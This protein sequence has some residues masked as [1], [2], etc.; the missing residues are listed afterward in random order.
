M[1]YKVDLHVHSHYSHDGCMRPD[2]IIQYAKAK[3]LDAVAICDH[4]HFF[5]DEIGDYPVI[6]GCEFSTPYGHLLGLFLTAPIEEKDFA[7]IVGAI[8]AQGGI[9]VLAHPFQHK[10]DVESVAHLVDGVE[11]WNSRACRKN[12]AAN[13]QAR[14]YARRHDLLWF[15]GSDAHVPE[16]IGNAVLTVEGE[17]LKSALLENRVTIEAVHSAPL[18]TAKSQRTKLKKEK[19]G[20]KAWLRWSLFAAKCLLTRKEN[21]HVVIGKDR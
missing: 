16:E 21:E 11:V 20:L 12:K 14:D 19:A 7:A 18:N 6:R 10:R 17:D 5:A 8:H 13:D 9:A 15:G 4:D 2:E 3:G 1:I